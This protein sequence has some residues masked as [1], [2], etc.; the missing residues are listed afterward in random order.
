M[1]GA[2][3]VIGLFVAILAGA[4]AAKR[5]PPLDPPL[6]EA[7]EFGLRVQLPPQPAYKR[8]AISARS[9]DYV[10]EYEKMRVPFTASR[11]LR[12]QIESH[13]EARHWLARRT[14]FIVLIDFIYVDRS[15]HAVR[16]RALCTDD[17]EGQ[18]RIEDHEPDLFR[19]RPTILFRT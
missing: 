2:L 13:N 14:R 16:G 19:Q 1:R 7:C 12:E 10:G 9:E 18:V 5:F 17:A 3:A 6:F 4:L 15:G 11:Q 8:L